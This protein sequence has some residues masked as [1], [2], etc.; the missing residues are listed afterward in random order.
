M[1][2]HLHH[3]PSVSCSHGGHDHAHIHEPQGHGHTHDFA[4]ANRAFFDDHAHEHS[5]GAHPHAGEL[6]TREVN[7]M[8]RFW[9]DLFDEE[10]TVV[11]DYACGVGASLHFI[12]KLSSSSIHIMRIWSRRDEG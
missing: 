1:S 2:E 6:A 8:R 11:M 5:S 10:Q 12:Q 3:I 7:A 4:A 9:P